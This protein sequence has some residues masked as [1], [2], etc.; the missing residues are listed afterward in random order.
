MIS[1]VIFAPGYFVMTD[2]QGLLFLF[3]SLRLS[4]KLS[5]IP[6]RHVC[7][8]ARARTVCLSIF[9][10][11]L[12]HSAA[13]E[14]IAYCPAA[15]GSALKYGIAG[16]EKALAPLRSVPV[17]RKGYPK[18]GPA[19]LRMRPCA[20]QRWVDRARKRFKQTRIGA[21]RYDGW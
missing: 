18:E 12:H 7:I 17:W 4:N 16:I 21:D 19:T 14:F 9:K 11:Q 6:T 10:C 1:K 3:E 8:Q 13:L 2:I 15:I 20:P 5:R